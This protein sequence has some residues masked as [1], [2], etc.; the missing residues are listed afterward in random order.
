MAARTS[1]SYSHGK[2]MLDKMSRKIITQNFKN[3]IWNIFSTEIITRSQWY[4][5]GFW[6]NIDIEY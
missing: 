4:N 5:M 6:Y 3:D 2:S 1:F